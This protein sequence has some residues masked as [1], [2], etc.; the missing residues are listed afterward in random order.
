MYIEELQIKNFKGISK[1]N[2]KCNEFFNV[3]IGRNN[4]G[5]S[6]IFE[7][8]LLWKKCYDKCIKKN[9]K[10]F[11]NDTTNKYVIFNELKFLRITEDLDLYNS[12]EDREILLEVV[13][14]EGDNKFNLGFKFERI[15]NPSNA[16]FRI[17]YSNYNQ[18]EM[19]YEY[20]S[21]LGKKLN[22]A[23]FIYQTKPISNIYI[24]EPFMT[25]GQILTKI[26]K[27]KSHEVL[28]NKIIN[29]R[30]DDKI[31]SLEDK[32][33]NVIEQDF[34]F[35]FKNKNR[36]NSDEYIELKVKTNEKELD[37]HL[38]GSGFL[39]IT[40]IF[41]SIEY[42]DSALNILLVDEPD[43]H[44]HSRL[45]KN[46][47]AELKNN[48]NTQT[49]IISHNESFV[50][51]LSEGELFFLNEDNK[52]KGFLENINIENFDLIKKELG[53]TIS[54]LENINFCKTIVFVEGEDDKDY[55]EALAD[56]YMR[57]KGKSKRDN[58]QFFHLRGKD[59]VEKKI[60]FN[61]RLLSQIFDSKKFILIYDKDFCTLE[62]VEIQKENLKRKLGNDSKV[63]FHDGYCIESTLFSDLEKLSLLLNKISMK[64]I[65]SIRSFVGNYFN[66]L[67]KHCANVS[68]EVCVS[69]EK[70][71][72]GQKKDSR[73]ELK[74]ITINH[75][76]REINCDI[77]NVKYI[78]NKNL[79]K[80]FIVKFEGNFDCK[81]ISNEEDS[82]AE[83]YS[84]ELFNKYIACVNREEEIF[85]CH[86]IL[87]NEVY[88]IS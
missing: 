43:S 53:G 78:M 51:S 27:G 3:V 8:M 19:F 22:E 87:L 62:Q 47:L 13:L 67:V 65:S 56:M 2:I 25:K 21:N 30:A 63:L 5:K 68:S 82:S 16:Y 49:F 77:N 71:F 17:H 18:F 45:Q 76:V 73:P 58:V 57:V 88:N 75:F 23:I 33:K 72:N 24:D 60:D 50:D 15:T 44:I 26:S 29:N 66:N 46:L 36:K 6:T 31:K 79:I 52:K 74:D 14:K 61:K 4:I 80:E 69:L 32:I 28:R 39:Q 41:S 42:I 40:E 84:S 9:Y 48:S 83:F 11:Y 85:E 35:E 12:S 7:G 64:D 59:Y 54:A 37:L 1:L 10:G 20:I 34:S 55:V 81:I 70:S 38:Q 86:K